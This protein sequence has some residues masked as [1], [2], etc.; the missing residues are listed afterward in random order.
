MPQSRGPIPTYKQLSIA[1]SRLAILSNPVTGCQV[2]L[3]HVVSFCGDCVPNYDT[4]E[5]QGQLS[6]K[7]DRKEAQSEVYNVDKTHS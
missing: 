6:I 2:P 5:K 3:V 4:F 7:S 1:S